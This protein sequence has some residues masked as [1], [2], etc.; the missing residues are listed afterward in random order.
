MTQ[1]MISLLIGWYREHKRI[2]PWRE[3]NDPY[4]VW[5]SE[6]MLQQTRVQ[7]VI[8]YYRRFMAALPDVKSLALAPDERL[9]KLWQGLGY[10]NRA[11]MMQ[12]AARQIMERPDGAFPTEYPELL[13]LPGV[14]EYT[15]GAVASIAFA[16]AVPAVDGN[17][18]RVMARLYDDHS[19]PDI[20]KTECRQRLLSAIPEDCPGDFNQALMELGATV[21][22]PSGA[23]LCARCPLAPFC[24]G[25]IR[26][27]AEELPVKKE[28]RPRRTET[29]TVYLLFHRGRVAIRKRPGR[30]LL[31]GL[32]EYPQDLAGGEGFWSAWNLHP[33]SVRPCAGGTHI[34]THVKW[35][36]AGVAAEMADEALPEGWVWASGEE[37]RSKYAIPS[38]FRCFD[39]RVKNV[40]NGIK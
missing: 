10:Y 34:F 32:W 30:G 7:S 22:L 8:S 37:L 1:E 31:A 12:K 24:L 5:V 21:C 14:G 27:T 13:L 9:M 17:V 4:A 36:M 2:L 19:S 35:D 11:R 25:R 38:A 28:K 6:I 39:K 33:I 15:A 18:C 16:R 29:R 23:P 26:E 3:T 40:L 20:L